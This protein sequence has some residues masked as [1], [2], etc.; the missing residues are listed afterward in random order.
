MGKKAANATVNIAQI[1]AFVKKGVATESSG[2][3][4]GL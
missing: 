2:K 3:L 4:A 1:L